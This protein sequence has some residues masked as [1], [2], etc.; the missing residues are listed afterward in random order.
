MCS[1]WGTL[2][3]SREDEASYLAD[4]KFHGVGLTEGIKWQEK[5]VTIKE[6][7]KK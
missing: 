5:K 7:E 4:L 1:S 2:M 6:K 3:T